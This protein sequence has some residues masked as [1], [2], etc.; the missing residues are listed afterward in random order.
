MVF[1]SLCQVMPENIYQSPRKSS[2]NS[3][4]SLRHPKR[5]P[6]VVADQKGVA[7]VDEHDNGKQRIAE[8]AHQA[9]H[10]RVRLRIDE[11]FSRRQHRVTLPRIL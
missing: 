2:P 8:Q 11:G 5:S 10:G 3:R 6:G 4:A 9:R 7:D 1:L